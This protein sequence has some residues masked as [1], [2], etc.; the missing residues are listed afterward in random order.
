MPSAPVMILS[1]PVINDTSV[2][3]PVCSTYLQNINLCTF[4]NLI[5]DTQDLSF[6]VDMLRH[7]L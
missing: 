3:L 7:K 2:C 4:T 5:I 1:S 6:T